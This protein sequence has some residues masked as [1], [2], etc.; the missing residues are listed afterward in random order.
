V[1]KVNRKIIR[2]KTDFKISINK[3]GRSYNAYY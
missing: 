3:L 1:V 2:S